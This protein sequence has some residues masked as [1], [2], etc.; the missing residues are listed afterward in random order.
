MLRPG[1][2]PTAGISPAGLSLGRTTV[3]GRPVVG[4]GAPG[5][6]P[7]DEPA[8]RRDPTSARLHSP[9]VPTA[10][11][12]GILELERLDEDVHR[13]WTPPGTN[14]PDIFGGQVASQA[15]RAAALSVETDHLPDSV[16]CY[17]L[18]RGRPELPID[19]V[20]ER[21][22]SGRTYTNR[23][24]EA[25]Q[26]GRTILTMLASFHAH[27]PGEEHELPMPEG[28]APP[29]AGED[30]S[31]EPTGWEVPFELRDVPM[32]GPGVRFWG[33]VTDPFPPDPVLHAC[34][35]L[36]AS[37]MRAGSPAMEAIG[38]DPSGK[39]PDPARQG[40]FGSLDHA[41]WFHRVPRVDRWFLSDVR[42]LTVRDA[43]GVVLGTMHDEDGH[44]L[45]TFAQEMFL[46]VPA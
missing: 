18:R 6:G 30:W 35:L 36:Y 8:A 45:A 16:H 21:T 3:P 29:T 13:A 12:A 22:R 43:R 40:N 26:E 17:F 19:L 14:R 39:S 20:V 9:A 15:L 5:A 25:R 37:D 32:A 11:L 33:R 46:K 23:R 2:R 42:V 41:L 38:V 7:G 34:A 28:V 1:E 24:V 27:E 31:N 10:T 44:H 4:A